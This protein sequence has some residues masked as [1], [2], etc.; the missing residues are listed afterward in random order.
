MFQSDLPSQALDKLISLAEGSAD[1]DLQ[2]TSIRFVL[3]VLQHLIGRCRIP[4]TSSSFSSSGNNNNNNNGNQFN[5]GGFN[6]GAPRRARRMDFGGMQMPDDANNNHSDSGADTKAS[7]LVRFAPLTAFSRLLLRRAVE[8]V[9][10]FVSENATLSS[11]S[12]SPRLHPTIAALASQS[13]LL[14]VLIPSLVWQLSALLQSGS[15]DEARPLMEAVLPLL[16]KL[17][18][19]NALLG[20]VHWVFV[21]HRSRGIHSFLCYLCMLIR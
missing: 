17:A 19:F 7:S 15:L 1:S 21:F 4:S 18:A 11:S 12:S 2:Q 16:P 9:D 13:P 6:F 10:Q 8:L 14:Q 20:S 3:T 5:D